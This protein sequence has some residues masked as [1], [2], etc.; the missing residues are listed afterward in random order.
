LRAE[1]HRRSL[2]TIE[3]LT[4]LGER[5]SFAKAAFMMCP[6]RDEDFIESPVGHGAFEESSTFSATYQL[7]RYS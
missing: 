4:A 7:P 2:K 1:A 3:M 5:R 6:F